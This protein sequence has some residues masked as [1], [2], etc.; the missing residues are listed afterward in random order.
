[1][2][3]EITQYFS[4]LGMHNLIGLGGGEQY[5]NLSRSRHS[6]NEKHANEGP[7]RMIEIKG[8]D[9]S[10]SAVFVA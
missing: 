1:M 5:T 8:V 9:C 2:Q 4:S 3:Q 6:N 7:H 10:N